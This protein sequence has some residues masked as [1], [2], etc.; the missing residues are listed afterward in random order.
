MQVF[1]SYAHT[2]ADTT[3]AKFLAASLK[4]VGVKAW[5]DETELIAGTPLQ[6]RI[7]KAIAESDYGLFLLSQSWLDSKWTSFELAQFARRDLSVVRLIPIYRVPRRKLVIPPDFVKVLGF[8]WLDDDPNIDARLWELYCAVTNTEPGP[9]DDWPARWGQVVKKGPATVFEG[10]PPRPL[11]P[12]P[13]RVRQSLYCDRA[14]QWSAVNDLSL[15]PSN[16]LILVPGSVGQDHDH[17]VQRV[18]HLL[19]QD[20]PR[21]MVTVDWPTRPRSEGEFLDN[22][23]A[24]LRVDSASLSAEVGRR[25]THDNLVLLH[26]CI[27]A[28]YVDADLVA[29][30]AKYLPRVLAEAKGAMSIKCVQPIEWPLEPVGVKRLL[31]LFR[32]TDGPSAEEGRTQAEELIR[33]LSTLQAESLPVFRLRD[34]SPIVPPDLVEF[35]GV[36][37][38]RQKQSDWLLERIEERGAQTPKDI[39][40]AIDDF[41][42]D[43][44]SIS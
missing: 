21:T 40:Q 14:V 4:S 34:L 11:R 44:R 20:P 18:Q 3:L 8:H 15:E 9:A 31:T 39:F 19:R 32:V 37:K 36:M 35:C 2:T 5:L 25:L 12:P 42:P 6:A 10:P 41:L 26:P 38:L 22:L 24:A 13:Q 30:Y 23:A 43:A 16:R 33:R 17:F 27:R 28:R 29:Y 1:I 7:E